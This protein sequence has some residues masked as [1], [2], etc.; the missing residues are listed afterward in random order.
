M[1]WKKKIPTSW[2]HS[3]KTA[4]LFGINAYGGA[5]NLNGCL[6]DLKTVRNSLPDFQI[7]EFKDREVTRK[8]FRGELTYVFTNAVEGDMIY[9]HYSGHGSFIPDTSGDEIDG[10]DET[11]YLYDGNFVDDELAELMTLIPYGVTVV[12]G[13][14]CC[15]SGTNTRDIIKT[16]FMPPK[17]FT[18][19]HKRVRR[20]FKAYQN[21]VL[22]SACSE[23]ETSS[24]ALINGVWQ[25]AYTFY[26]FSCLSRDLTYRKWGEQ[27][28]LRLPN[29]NFSQTPQIEGADYLLDRLVFQ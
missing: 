8:C 2:E 5:N 16:R 13:M 12:L 17:K 19:A 25:G 6:N 21:Y 14:D 10:Y 27:I 29:K 11:L 7:R 1:C 28:R 22:M 20:M 3:T 23:N 4:L 24:D 26:A 18:P 9:V 15:Y